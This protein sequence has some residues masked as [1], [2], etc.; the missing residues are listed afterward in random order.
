MKYKEVKV[1]E[2]KLYKGPSE[3]K[4]REYVEGQVKKL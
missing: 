1:R 3:E 4:R 2:T